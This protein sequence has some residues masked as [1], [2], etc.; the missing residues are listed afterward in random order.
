MLSFLL[1]VDNLSATEGGA[2]ALCMTEAA[3]GAR[4]MHGASCVDKSDDTVRM[5]CSGCRKWSCAALWCACGVAMSN[6]Q[7]VCQVRMR[8]VSSGRGRSRRG[9]CV[10]SG[11]VTVHCRGAGG[12][13]AHAIFR[14]GKS[15][16]YRFF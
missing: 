14:P 7:G 5:L 3:G 1:S 9:G 11:A 10:G 2:C 12:V 8:G 16:E 15:F 6:S 13:G 4:R